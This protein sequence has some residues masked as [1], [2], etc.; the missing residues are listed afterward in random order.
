MERKQ[1]DNHSANLA[2]ANAL[3]ASG[4]HA[5]A[6]QIYADLLASNADD[7]AASYGLGIIA[8]HAGRYDEARERLLCAS[9]L[10][11]QEACYRATLG[12]IERLRGDFAAAQLALSLALELDPESA[13]AHNNMGMLQL[14]QE[15]FAA[16]AESFGAALQLNPELAM[17][18]YNLGIALKE[19]NQLDAAQD[20]YRQAIARRADF[21]EA[22]VNLAIAL[23]LD[24]QL[25]EGFEEYEWRLKLPAAASRQ[26]ATPLWD[27]RI[28]PAGSLLLTTEQGAGDAI[29]LARFIPFVAKE[30]MRIIVQCPK[31]L[32]NLMQSV[33][34]VS[35]TYA[36]DEPLPPHSAHLPLPSLP[37]LF[38]TRLDKIPLNIPYLR[39]AYAAVTAWRER[40]YGLGETIKVGLRWAGNPDNSDDYRRSCAL[41]MFAGLRQVGQMSLIGLNNEP[42][43]GEEAEVAAKLGLVDY[44]AE[45]GDFAD[46]AAL[47]AN[48]DLV[49]SV[50]TAVLHLAGALGRPSWGLLRYSPHWPWLLARDDSPW[51]PGMQLFR[52][53]RPGDW[54]TVTDHVVETLRNAMRITRDGG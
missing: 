26:D 37:R 39:P 43:R 29:Q 45:L 18:W 35:S 20:A 19:S 41:G 2:R 10:R 15:R 44:A 3:L 40:L 6:A 42:L 36:P 23:L 25:E 7:A 50:D 22:H 9:E 27:G 30:G 31:A 5:E 53:P 38:A 16:A 1:V 28:D 52:Q 48:L 54:K 47:I 11:P 17:A 34:G 32:E 12:E 8:W 33:E 21:V 49:I 51:Y 46:S 24:G 13:E 14:S 4:A